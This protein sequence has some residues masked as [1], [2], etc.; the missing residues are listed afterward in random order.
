[1]TE[2]DAA[3]EER[4]REAAAHLQRATL[5]LI[6][7][8]RAMLDIAEEAVREPGGVLAVLTETLG[9]LV[10]VAGTVAPGWAERGRQAAGRPTHAS[11]D[12]EDVADADNAE[13]REHRP[14]ERRGGR[15]TP[16][17]RPGVEHIRIS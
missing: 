7:A 6:E 10:E 1:M 12:T 15:T 17:R 9:G 11:D 3:R 4:A 13:R 2:D 14:A 8:A 16:P 5:E